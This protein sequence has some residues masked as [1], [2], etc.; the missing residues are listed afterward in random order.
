MLSD[1]R[2]PGRR[3][4]RP[5]AD[6]MKGA[7][8]MKT[9]TNRSAVRFFYHL[10]FFM[11]MP[12]ILVLTCAPPAGSEIRRLKGQTVYVP[13]YSDIYYGDREKPFHLTV[14]LSIRNTDPKHP[15][16]VVSIDYFD[17]EGKLLR[18]E[19]DKE[20]KISPMAST[21]CVIRESDKSGGAGAGFRVVWRSEE[22]VC[23][24]ILESVMI[25]TSTQQGISFTSRG[26]AMEETP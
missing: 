12:A 13:A 24:P 4:A 19:L 22:R 9:R 11:V 6:A 26:Q 5:P 2:K 15:L 1:G 16:T 10:A 14:T 25:G 20:T 23:E 21:S 17:S 7:I 18:K 8:P 3:L